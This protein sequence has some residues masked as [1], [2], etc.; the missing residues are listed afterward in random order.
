MVLPRPVRKLLGF[1]SLCLFLTWGACSSSKSPQSP[2][3]ADAHA[4]DESGD[5]AGA[6]TQTGLDA[7]AVQHGDASVQADAAADASEP[8]EPVPAIDCGFVD[9]H[10]PFTWTPTSVS[11]SVFQTAPN[12]EV[13]SYIGSPD[14]IDRGDVWEMYYAMS[15]A[16]GVGRIGHATSHDRGLSWARDSLRMEPFGTFAS[17][18]LDTPAVLY[19]EGKYKLY[20]FGNKE[21]KTQGGQIGYAVRDGNAFTFPLTAPALGVGDSAA[22]DAL[23]VES[24]V[25]KKV[26]SQYLMW[27]TANDPSWVVRHGV[28][29][30]SDGV[31]WQKYA[32][33]PVI[34]AADDVAKFDS[35]FPGGSA[36]VQTPSGDFLM[37]FACASRLSYLTPPL[38]ANVCLATSP[39]GDGKH[40][41]WYPSDVAKAPLV[42]RAFFEALHEGTLAINNGPIN[43]SVVLDRTE[44][45]FKVF[46][47]NQ[48]TFLGL[49]TLPVCKG[50]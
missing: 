20:V 18:F 17:A 33:N 3:S 5:G 24:P 42:P 48:S 27:Y 8:D 50:M 40:F 1:S 41:T 21:L 28:A 9:F 34:S 16:K 47:E 14:V 30:S 23:W 29:T 45:V 43:M 35:F 39:K 38:I 11:M 26:G 2:Q 6:H 19:D 12:S 7:S 13:E 4:P 32:G 49:F 44:G 37:F 31:S 25:V 15:D 22:W 36:V 10:T 46:Y